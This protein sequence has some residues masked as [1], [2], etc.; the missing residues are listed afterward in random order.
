MSPDS[1]DEELFESAR[2]G[3]LARLTSL[4]DRHPDRIGIRTE[5]YGQTMLHLAAIA[6]HLHIVELLIARGADVNARDVGDNTYPMHWA[7]A[8]GHLDVVRRLADAGGDVTGQDDDHALEVI[9]WASAWEGCDDDAHREVVELLLSRGARHHIFSA[10]AMNLAEEVRRIVAA[11]PSALSRTL[12]R[13]EDF[14]RPLHFAV[15]MDKPEMVKLLVELGADPL[16][17]DGSGYTASMYAKNSDVDRAVIEAIRAR[18]ENDLFTA[19]AVRDLDTASR[20]VEKP[21]EIDAEGVLHRMS[22]RGDIAAVR[23]LLDHGADPNALW[24]HWDAK[25]TPLHLATLGGH[26]EVARMLLAAGANPRI[27]DSKH[28][29][30]AIGWATFFRQPEFATLLETSGGSPP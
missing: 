17:T 21:G 2:T 27:R 1:I 10:I 26:T 19:L 7:A 24:S 22:K 5:P 13:N 14:Q 28:D 16:S 20:L 3:D 6:G 12:S 29:S 25:V 9:G 15:R 11:D 23:W 18:A 4:L 8:A 30:D